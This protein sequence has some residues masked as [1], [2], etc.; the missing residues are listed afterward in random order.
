MFVKSRSFGSRPAPPSLSP[1]AYRCT[2]VPAVAYGTQQSV[3]CSAHT[4]A[5]AP[6]TASTQASTS[7]PSASRTSWQLLN[8]RTDTR[9]IRHQ[10]THMTT[11]ARNVRSRT[12]S[13]KTLPPS[14]ATNKDVFGTKPSKLDTSTPTTGWIVRALF[15]A[16]GTRAQPH[17]TTTPYP[18][19]PARPRGHFAEANATETPENGAARRPAPR[20]R[21]LA[22][23]RPCRTCSSSAHCLHAMPC[24]S[25]LDKGLGRALG[26]RSATKAGDL[27]MRFAHVSM[28]RRTSL[29][30]GETATGAHC[31]HWRG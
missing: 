3:P 23:S 2:D 10:Q 24:Q 12:K 21:T 16:P 6:G 27:W 25:V 7:Q 22:R 29:A 15:R 13:S 19:P 28:L 20:G 26:P 5:A 14:P 4:P 9:P 18:P 30:P 11:R 8:N 17:R 31:V 1:P